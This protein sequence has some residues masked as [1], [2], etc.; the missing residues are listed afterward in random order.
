MLSLLRTLFYIP[1]FN[2]LILLT[3]IM[4][5]YS[6]GWAIIVMTVGLRLILVPSTTHQI[7]QQHKMKKLQPEL[8]ELQERHK[9]DRET[10]AR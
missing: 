10:L 5:G 3:A 6:V 9:Y 1:L 2:L 7:R 4:P 8:K